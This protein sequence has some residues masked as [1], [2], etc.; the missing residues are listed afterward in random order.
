MAPAVAVVAGVLSVGVI[1]AAAVGPGH[2]FNARSTAA[3]AAVNMNCTLIVPASP[4]TAQ[5]LATPYQLTAT[6]PADGPCNEANG[7]QTAFVQGAIID[8][9]TGQISVYNP[10]VIDAGT[11]PAVAPVAPTLPAGAVVGLWFGFNGNT[12]SFEG[13]DQVGATTAAATTPATTTMPSPTAPAAGAA[14]TPVA[15]IPATTAAPAT[16]APAATTAP[17][18]TATAPAATPTATG[19]GAGL[20]QAATKLQGRH[21]H[22]TQPT[23]SPT[24]TAAASATPT[25]TAVP[26]STPA[27]GTVPASTVPASTGPASTAPAGSVTAPAVTGTTPPAGAN[28]PAASG[29]PDAILQA[30]NC[31]TGESI[32]GAFS[33]FTQVGACNAVAFFQAANAAIAAGKLTVPNPGTA[34][35][36]QPCLTTRNFGVIDQDQSD[37]VT[38]KYLANGNGQTAQFTAANQQA[39]AGATM[40]VNGSDNALIN[41]FM[42]PALGCTDWQVPDL[43]NAGATAPALPLDELQAAAFA[44]QSGGPAA[45][46]PLND[47]MVLDGNG[48]Q[49][50]DKTNAYRATVDQPALNAGETPAEYCGDMESIQGTRLQQ[51]VNLLIGQPSPVPANASN[52]FTFLAMRLQQSFANLNCQN[53]GLQNDVSTT[54]DGNGVVV[55]ACFLQ[56]VNAVTPGAGNPTAGMT[57]C[58]ATTAAGA[59]A[60]TAPAASATPSPG[61][62][63]TV[64]PAPTATGGT[65]P[66]APPGG[67]A[68]TA[69]RR[70]RHWWY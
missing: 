60:T 54:V 14:T 38:T 2:L 67:N 1:V 51:D 12:L 26:T 31:V 35:D 19:G 62:T 64:A 27:T 70:H 5:G 11:Q 42:D 39:V 40:L 61:P 63:S 21:R 36:G 4:L 53:F 52:L 23:A 34:K 6:N 49:S 44:G 29:T 18:V 55:A 33:S 43:A 58:P 10:L 57:T 66:A 20:V 16:T 65:A 17:T 47:P 48:N 8:P 25:A 59:P 41:Y 50:A 22:Q 32:A 15:T 9:A 56:Q 37:N 30:A 7:N 68:G 13:T 24:A 45:L 3:A 46:V 28:V 69:N